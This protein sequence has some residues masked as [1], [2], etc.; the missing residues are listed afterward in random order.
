[1]IF[2]QFAYRNV[3][4][5]SRIYAA[6]FMASCFSVLVFFMYSMLLFH[7]NI[8]D[9]ILGFMSLFGMVVA[10]A[11]LVIFS[12]F[13]L[14]YSMSAFLEAR[15]KEFGVLFH[16]GMDEKQFGRLVFL[17]TMLIGIA[18]IVIGIGFGFAFTRFFFM[19]VREIL[20][21]DELNMYFAWQPFLLTVGVFL[22]A[23]MIVAC[24]SIA[25][26]RKRRTIDL[27]KERDEKLQDVTLL[28][29]LYGIGLI[30]LSYGGLIVSAVTESGALLVLVPIVGI[31][32]T[33]YLFSDTLPYVLERFRLNKRRYW[34]SSLVVSVSETIH[35]I[36]TNV[37]MFFVITLVSTL[38]F[39]TI[40]ALATVASYTTQYER[41]NPLGMVYKSTIDNPYE[42]QHISSLRNQLEAEGLSYNLSRFTVI[43]QTS[44]YT[45]YEVEVFRESEIN[46]LLFSLGYPLVTLETGEAMFIPYSE[47]AIAKLSNHTVR[48]VLKENGI[49]LVIDSVYPQFI[50]PGNFVSNNSIIVSDE[51]FMKIHYPLIGTTFE[52]SAYRLYTF[53]V[54]QWMELE[55]VGVVIDAMVDEEDGNPYGYELPFYFENAGLNYSFVLATYSLFTLIVLLVAAVFLLAAGSFVYFKMYAD[56][57]RSQKHFDVLQRMGLTEQEMHRLVD[58]H[59]MPQFFLPWIV[60]LAHSSVVLIS[61]NI[62]LEHFVNISIV[63]EV[64]IGFLSLIVIQ[65]IYYYLIRWRYIAHLK[66]D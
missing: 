15:A 42:G 53:D 45:K 59:L 21:L 57:E 47:D 56:L 3:I 22:A 34:R 51:D 4:R 28:R 48:T 37:R 33:Y 46:H 16:L 61:F 63:D 38:T 60:A 18:S 35:T 31:F 5:N 41:L 2:R 1:M 50:F 6:F 66:Q 7:P 55:D 26:Q 32:G 25:T 8:D 27:L 58:R 20:R 44:S 11:V 9:S 49:P 54:P 10:E 13:F 24:V 62:L 36:R 43:Q 29:A 39:L 23:F 40:G 17:E 30:A 65:V 12:L 52:Q 19:I 64:M 14:F